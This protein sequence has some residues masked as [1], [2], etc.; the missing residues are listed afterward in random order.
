MEEY[1]RMLMGIAR[2]YARDADEVDDLYQA[3]LIRAWKQR[4]T[5]TGRGTLGGWLFRLSHN[6]GLSYRRSK[7][8]ERSLRLRFWAQGERDVSA[9]RPAD[10]RRVAMQRLRVRRLRTAIANLPEQQRTAV[11]LMLLDGLSVRE[12]AAEMRVTEAT[13]RSHQRHALEQLKSMFRPEECDNEV[14]T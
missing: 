1:G 11:S 14:H 7:D 9:W 6:A 10:S 12:I 5:Y 3:I 4:L 8:R 13:V 2:G